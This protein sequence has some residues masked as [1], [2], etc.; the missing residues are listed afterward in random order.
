MQPSLA[1]TQRQD[2]A[3]VSDSTLSEDGRRG[4]YGVAHRDF[5]RCIRRQIDVDPRAEPDETKT[6]PAPEA[7]AG[8]DVTQDAPRDQSCNLH[9]DDVHAVGSRDVQRI[10]LVLERGLVQSGIEKPALVI[11][12]GL[13]FAIDRTAI[14]MDVE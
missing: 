4:V 9:A 3:A 6:L 12:P 10:A 1:A 5:G 13:H 14:R 2:N 7:I 8:P 11:P